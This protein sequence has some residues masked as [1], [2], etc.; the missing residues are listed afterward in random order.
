MDMALQGEPVS[1]AFLEVSGAIQG[2]YGSLKPPSNLYDSIKTH[3]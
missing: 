1:D 2:I 3:L